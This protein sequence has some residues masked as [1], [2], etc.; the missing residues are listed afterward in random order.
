MWPTYNTWLQGTIRSCS[1]GQ[2]S[3]VCIAPPAG[4]SDLCCDNPTLWIQQG[5][6]N[7]AGEDLTALTSQCGM[8]CTAFW[9]LQ[10]ELHNLGCGHAAVICCC[11]GAQHNCIPEQLLTGQQEL[12]M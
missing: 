9:Q 3:A 6:T 2:C 8:H 7:V 11:S 5:P 4:S 1:A 12:H 10:L